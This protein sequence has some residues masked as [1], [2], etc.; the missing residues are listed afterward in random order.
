[1]T[2][3]QISMLR[4]F[5]ENPQGEPLPLVAALALVMAA[6]AL[7][8]AQNSDRWREAR[9]AMVKSTIAH[10]SDRPA[11]KN[12]RVIGAMLTVPRHL[13]VPKEIAR[14]AYLDRPLPIG[15]DQTISQPYMVAVMTELLDPQ[16]GDRVLE[17]GTGSGYQAAI[18][19]GLVAGVYTI[20][21][22]PPLARQAARRLADLGYEN[23][24]VREGDGYL[25]WPEKAPFDSIIVTAGANH[26]PRPLLE[27]LKPGGVMVIPVGK[28]PMNL[29]L[30]VIRRGKTPDDI[31]IEHIMPVAFVPLT[32]E[33]ARP[34]D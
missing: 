11:V 5:R 1:M 22:V 19:A 32:G 2:H 9:A 14:Y 7:V 10:P 27:Q 34:Q 17:V 3:K 26:I 6:L 25:G 29:T 23:V 15:N 20:E 8:A 31:E 30:Q 18:L 24:H 28:P 12:R 4:P 13:F 21:I 33:H 16:P